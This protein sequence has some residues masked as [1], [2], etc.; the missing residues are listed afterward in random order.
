[1]L[2]AL[3]Q[4]EALATVDRNMSHLADYSESRVRAIHRMLDRSFAEGYGVNAGDIIPGVNAFGLPLCDA[5]GSPFAAISLAG[6]AQAFPLARR[7]E[8]HHRLEEA[9]I[10]LRA[11]R[12]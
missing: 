8:I 2:L 3:P 7:S 9:A 4:P 5:T 1:M 12:A 11:A 10:G 6:S